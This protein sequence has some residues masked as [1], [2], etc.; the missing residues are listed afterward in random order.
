MWQGRPGRG[1]EASQFQGVITRRGLCQA[2]PFGGK[3]GRDV[4]KTNGPARSD[5]KAQAVPH[6]SP[7]G[8]GK[9]KR[10]STCGVNLD[11]GGPAPTAP[12]GRAYKEAG[13]I[14]PTTPARPF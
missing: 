13:G 5:K 11:G 12:G 6:R 10:F 9:H 14:L 7:A 4:A 3:V 8:P 2:S 1:P